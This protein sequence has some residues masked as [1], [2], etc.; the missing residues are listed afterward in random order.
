MEAPK[1]ISPKE[2]EKQENIQIKSNKNKLFNLT[3]K[4]NSNLL[5]ISSICKDDINIE[6]Y[7][8]IFTMEKIGKIKY[9][10][11]FNSLN[12]IYDEI[13]YLIKGKQNEIKLNEDGNIIK[14]I[15][16]LEGLKFKQIEICLEKK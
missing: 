3:I 6:E 10:L 1:P 7:E 5:I 16:P 11:L 4:Y 9:F 14:L 15:L 8:E 2:F 12:E 13:I